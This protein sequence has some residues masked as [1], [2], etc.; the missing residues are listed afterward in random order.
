MM[1]ANAMADVSDRRLQAV[2]GDRADWRLKADLKQQ[3]TAAEFA[4]IRFVKGRLGVVCDCE[5]PL[6]RQPDP[7]A[8]VD[9]TLLFGETVTVFET[10]N[11]FAWAQNHY[12]S[13]VG[14]GALDRIWIPGKQ[15][16]RQPTHYVTEA[17]IFAYDQPSIKAAPV[18]RLGLGSEIAV[19]E[20][21]KPIH[22][23][24]QSNPFLAFQFST[25]K[26]KT[27]AY[28]E[29]RHVAKKGIW[30]SDPAAVALQLCHIPYLWGGGGSLGIDCSG[31]IQLAFRV[32]GQ[33]IPRDSDL[34]IKSC[35][36]L[37][38]KEK[39][40]RNDLVFWP[41]HVGIMADST[42][43]IHANATDMRVSV[44]SLDEAIDWIEKKEGL[45]PSFFGRAFFG[46]V[47]SS[48]DQ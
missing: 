27:T 26:G 40:Q 8:P 43:L 9:S 47:S 16:M 6:H 39:L 35:T 46:Q 31:L 1:V 25:S 38:T 2:R 45:R 34:Q 48:V 20:G 23:P 33:K 4:K 44:W 3:L 30:F 18:C 10:K 24:G 11:R 42:R 17:A 29:E 22:P 28:V 32:C 19:L 36:D 14:Y 37:Q 15:Q 7:Q 13:Y 5:L 41:G 12:D 21:Q